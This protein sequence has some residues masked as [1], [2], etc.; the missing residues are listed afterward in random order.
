M[1]ARVQPQRH[2][3]EPALHAYAHDF[4]REILAEEVF[5]SLV[6]T[7]HFGRA[8]LAVELEAAVHDANL[9][10]V[11]QFIHVM[12]SLEKHLRG[13]RSQ[14]TTGPPAPLCPHASPDI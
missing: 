11:R 6:E 2:L 14:L 8:D 13:H 4:L 9:K 3:F 12:I 7:Q 10:Y 5:E 1:D